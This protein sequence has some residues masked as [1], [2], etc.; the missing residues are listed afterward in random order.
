MS[1]YTTLSPAE[2]AAFMAGYG[3]TLQAS[4]P[5][6]S[7]IENSNWFVSDRAGRQYVLTLFEHRG[8][9]EVQQLAQLMHQLARQGIPVAEPLSTAHGITIHS[10]QGKP[11]QLA[12]RLK[13]SHPQ[14]PDNAICRQMGASLAALHL[15][16]DRIEQEGQLTVIPD[17]GLQWDGLAQRMHTCVSQD[18]RELLMQVFDH[19]RPNADLPQGIVHSDLFR[20]N[21][22][23]DQGKLS[24]I[25]DF[26]EWGR[27]IRLLDCAVAINE[28]CS[29]WPAVGLNP[30][31][32][33]AFCEGYQNLLPWTAEENTALP[34]ALAVAAARFWL[35]RLAIQL[36]IQVD[37]QPNTQHVTSD[38]NPETI[39]RKD[40]EEMRAMVVSRLAG[41]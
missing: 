33:S 23:F 22:L 29:E 9:T 25:L 16:F 17:G 7:G 1:V 13:G 24:G 10:L 14:T 19:W 34:A 15:A 39:L 31:K 3:L 28:F 18:D 8:M 5:I 20:D 12:P 41:H 40:P 26:S 21:V 4:Q 37:S 30:Q 32:F 38:Q 27:D 35:S 36:A 6:L 2:I 11:A